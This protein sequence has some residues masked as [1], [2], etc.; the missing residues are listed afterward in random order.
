MLDMPAFA[1]SRHALRRFVRCLAL[2]ACSAFAA[3]AFAAGPD[4]LETL[5]KEIAQAIAK[6]DLAPIRHVIAMHAAAGPAPFE[7]EV[8][9]D[10]GKILWPARPSSVTPDEWAALK[11]SKLVYGFPE[12][13]HL[14]LQLM[15]LDED[16]KRDL[17]IESYLGGTGLFSGVS[18]HR[19][20]GNQFVGQ[21]KDPDDNSFYTINGRGSDQEADWIRLGGRVYLA[22]RNGDYGYDEL[23]LM[24]AFGA[25]L[26]EVDGLVV[27][28]RYRHRVSDKVLHGEYSPPT[29]LDP[30]LRR[31]LQTALDQIG[32]TPAQDSG[33]K[34][35][36]CPLP[37]GMTEDD[38]NWP[39]FGP[40]HYT[41][42]IV[43]DLPV[44]VGTQCHAAR[45]IAYRS[46]YLT[47]RDQV[48]TSLSYM[49]SP[50]DTEQEIEV[51]TKRTP[52]RVR[53]G[54]FP[55]PTPD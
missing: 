44:Q 36:Q 38:S 10:D 41:F 27:E 7:V 12:N 21:K 45:L 20:V 40:G 19:R 33:G 6:G 24:R 23:F 13:H 15:D 29:P 31:A 55:L 48:P 16:G 9:E 2:F 22:Y 5:R 53:R 52:V 30:E 25:P 4:P 54:H 26:N 17:I 3:R 8:A 47:D 46:S 28:Y 18:V 42:G 50:D 49:R 39:W 34:F 51:Q 14:S 32:D 43:A 11:R 37:E 1:P 35:P